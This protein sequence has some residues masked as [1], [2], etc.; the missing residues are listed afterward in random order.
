MRPGLRLVVASS[1]DH[2]TSDKETERALLI[3]QWRY[4]GNHA[5]AECSHGP[6]DQ[7]NQIIGQQAN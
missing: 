3:A 7:F 1:E 5:D 6:G 4:H 2:T